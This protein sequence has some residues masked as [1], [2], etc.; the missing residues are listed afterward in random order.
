MGPQDVRRDVQE[1]RTEPKDDTV[2]KLMEMCQKQCERIE[3]LEK[4]LRERPPV[5][6][7]PSAP[8]CRPPLFRRPLFGP[9]CE[10]LHH[11]E[12]LPHCEPAP[13][14]MAPAT[15]TESIALP[16]TMPAGTPAKKTAP[17]ID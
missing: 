2:K 6:C 11:C 12:P 17:T 7:P 13:G 4:C 3:H 8:E 9:R 16:R 14:P 1:Q 15:T 5:V 10:P